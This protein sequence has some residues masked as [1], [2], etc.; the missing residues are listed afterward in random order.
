MRWKCHCCRHSQISVE[1]TTCE[2]CGRPS[3]YC[4]KCDLLDI[5]IV[6]NLRA[7]QVDDFLRRTNY[8]AGPSGDVN[9]ADDFGFT[10]LHVATIAQNASVAALLITS[11]ALIEAATRK[12]WRPLH[13]AAR[14]G[15]VEMTSILIRSGANPAPE[16]V[17]RKTPLHLSVNLSV[18][19]L[20]LK[21]G[22]PK[23]ARDL[24]DEEECF[25]GRNGSV[26]ARDSS[27]RQ[28][29]ADVRE[30]RA[31]AQRRRHEAM[32]KIYIQQNRAQHATFNNSDEKNLV[33][34]RVCVAE[35]LMPDS[36]LPLVDAYLAGHRHA[37]ASTL[38]EFR[39]VYARR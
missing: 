4:E 38:L 16:T 1:R 2:V 37:H 20:L 7:E 10:P 23:V 27:Q 14:F 9:K 31:E 5:S 17:G 21:A 35:E 30:I 28:V 24:I 22:A 39:S 15:C 25:Q 29:E 26:T 6:A 36:G 12:G 32:T 34:V 33:N 13:F 8:D 3:L 19:S 18:S 11:G